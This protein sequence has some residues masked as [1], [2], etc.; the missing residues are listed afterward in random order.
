[1]ARFI[2]ILAFFLASPVPFLTA[3]VLNPG[4]GIEL[5]R[6]A[7]GFDIQIQNNLDLGA[8]TQSEVLMMFGGTSVDEGNWTGSGHFFGGTLSAIVRPISRIWRY[9]VWTTGIGDP[10]SA[11]DVRYDLFGSNGTSGVLSHVGHPDQEID[12]RVD[13]EPVKVVGATSKK[14][15][16]EGGGVLIL[17]LDRVRIPGEYSGTL[18]VTLNHF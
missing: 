2:P 14:V 1:M 11:L 10:V 18:V 6:A 4:S 12:V 17:E 5:A 13:P 15:I 3:Q 7:P 8:L 9:Q 16:L